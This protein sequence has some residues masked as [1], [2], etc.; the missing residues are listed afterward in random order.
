M[1]NAICFCYRTSSQALLAQS[2][3]PLENAEPCLI[4]AGT[5]ATLAT[6]QAWLVL[7]P[8]FTF[9]LITKSAAVYGCILAASFA[10]GFRRSGWHSYFLLNA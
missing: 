1:V 2:F 10:A 6:R 5:V 8:A 4:P 9:V 7:L 3:I